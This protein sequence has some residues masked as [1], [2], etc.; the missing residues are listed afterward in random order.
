MNKSVIRK[1]I[2]NEHEDCIPINLFCNDLIVGRHF[3]KIYG[4]PARFAYHIPV[5]THHTTPQFHCYI[6]QI[7]LKKIKSK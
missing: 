3:I 7:E 4:R 6:F 2:M 5:V 1:Y